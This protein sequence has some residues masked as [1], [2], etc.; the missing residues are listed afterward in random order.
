MI[1]FPIDYGI[2]ELLGDRVAARECYIAILEMDDHLQTINIEEQRTVVEL[3]E[4][5]EEI[6]LCD[7]RPD[8]TTK[9]DTLAS[10]HVRQ[11]LTTFLIENQDIF[12]WNHEDMPGINPLVMVHRLN[13]SP[14][15][16][17]IHQKKRVFAQE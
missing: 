3:V 17:P 5:L 4:K 16:P 9:V 12:A 8:R 13:V 15:F 11:A 14:A 10:L 1:K 7:S 6:L 2:R